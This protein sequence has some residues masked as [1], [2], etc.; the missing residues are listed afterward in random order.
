MQNWKDNN[1]SYDTPISVNTEMVSTEPSD[2]SIDKVSSIT[3]NLYAGNV[4]NVSLPE[5]IG[6][7]TTT[8]NIR[9]LYY[10]KGIYFNF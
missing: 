7:F 9:D 5:P 8:E 3:F 1:Y 6:S 4:K 10:N 2:N